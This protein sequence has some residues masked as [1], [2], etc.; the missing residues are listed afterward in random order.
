MK[1]VSRDKPLTELEP[2][3]WDGLLKRAQSGDEESQNDLCGKIRVRLG[4]ILQYRLWGWPAEDYEDILQDTLTV[5]LQKLDEIKS[6]PHLYALRVLR[7]KIG[8]A[9][10]TQNKWVRSELFEDRSP[11]G[12]VAG[13]GVAGRETTAGGD[14]TE[15]LET[16]DLV[17]YISQAIKRLALF[18]QTIFLAILENQTI[19]EVWQLFRQVEPNLKRSTFDKRIFD[20]RQKLKQLVKDEIRLE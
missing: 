4:P 11:I 5:F 17:N 12:V 16:K 8:E 10:R 3:D 9:L 18:C 6:N 14:F 1:T 13:G 7:N 15:E 20:C 19:G 2:I